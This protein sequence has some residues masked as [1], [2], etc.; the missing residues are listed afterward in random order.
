MVWY[1]PRDP[2]YSGT[3][4]RTGTYWF[5]P[6]PGTTDADLEAL[7]KR[8]LSALPQPI[9]IALWPGSQITLHVSWELGS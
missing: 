3:E 2:R 1:E 8:Y 7:K 5:I 9:H 6:K 4:V